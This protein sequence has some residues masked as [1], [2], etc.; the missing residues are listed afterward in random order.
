FLRRHSRVVDLDTFLADDAAAG[1]APTVTITFDDGYRSFVD[2][3]VPIV[4]A[5]KV[6]VAWFVPTAHVDTEE[7]FWFDRLRAQVLHSH[8]THVEL[9]GRQWDLRSWNR[10][11]A[12]AA[13]S[14]WLKQ[15]P[16]QTRETS[17]ARLS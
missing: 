13:I 3:I 14:R 11:Y 12:A 5:A 7:I 4:T 6:P 8:R 15:Q 16:P 1:D 2:E 10:E 17:M 9:D